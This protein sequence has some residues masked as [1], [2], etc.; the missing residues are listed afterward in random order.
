MDWR[1]EL[2]SRVAA[3]QV[4]SSELKSQPHQKDKKIAHMNNKTKKIKVNKNNNKRTSTYSLTYKSHFPEDKSLLQK[5]I[6]T[7]YSLQYL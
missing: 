3:L 4:G 5:Y 2:S 1:C 6:C 7:G